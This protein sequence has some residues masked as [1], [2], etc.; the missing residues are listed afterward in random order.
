M[1]KYKKNNIDSFKGLFLGTED[2]QIEGQVNIETLENGRYLPEQMKKEEKITSAGPSI[3][4]KKK[5]RPKTGREL[6]RRISFTI[7]PSLYDKASEKAYREGKSV[8][9]VV[10]EFLSEYVE[11]E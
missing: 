4:G 7:L 10:S 6:K 5:G 9:E 11:N 8:S 2:E 1:S 3:S